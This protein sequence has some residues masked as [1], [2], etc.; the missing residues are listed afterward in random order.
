MS[1]SISETSIVSIVQCKFSRRSEGY[2]LSKIRSS[3]ASSTTGGGEERT[4]E[5]WV[6][7]RY[8]RELYTYL[9]EPF[10][11]NRLTS[12]A[13]RNNIHRYWGRT[14]EFWTGT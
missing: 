9:F 11:E 3:T 10:I 12:F 7:Q 2:Y 4:Y 5:D 14:F 6:L 8:G 1:A 13:Q